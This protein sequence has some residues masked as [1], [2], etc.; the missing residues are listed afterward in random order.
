MKEFKRGRVG[1]WYDYTGE[2]CPNCGRVRVLMTES[3]KRVCEK[4]KWIIEDQVYADEYED[5][6]DY[7]EHFGFGDIYD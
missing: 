5:D 2:T 1:A 4:C 6:E 3:C 7:C